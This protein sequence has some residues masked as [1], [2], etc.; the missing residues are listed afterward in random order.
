MVDMK[1]DSNEQPLM[2]HFAQ[3][4][5]EKVQI[6]SLKLI[7]AKGLSSTVAEPT[8]AA[9]KALPARRKIDKLESLY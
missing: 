9:P 1:E 7:L 6:N 2:H 8:S 4:L 5:K 3:A